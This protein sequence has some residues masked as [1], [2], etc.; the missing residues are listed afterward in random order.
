MSQVSFGFGVPSGGAEWSKVD[1]ERE[2]R[3]VK[4]IDPLIEI[5][6]VTSAAYGDATSVAERSAKRVWAERSERKASDFSFAQAQVRVQQ[7]RFLTGERYAYEYEGAS[8]AA[9]GAASRS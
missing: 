3:T 5:S 1:D 9:G 6:V 2:L 7:F 8:R 4:V